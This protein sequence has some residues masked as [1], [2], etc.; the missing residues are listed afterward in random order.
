GECGA[1]A[2][3]FVAQ[4]FEDGAYE[5]DHAKVLLLK[6]R[7]FDAVT[8]ADLALLAAAKAL[9]TMEGVEPLSHN[10]VLREFDERVVSQGLLPAALWSAVREPL[11]SAPADTVTRS[12]A[13]L[14]VDAVHR[15]LD[16][17]RSHYEHLTGE[18]LATTTP[19]VPAE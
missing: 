9:L 12:T 1:A 11:H 2:V 4:H 16:A 18:S 17:C 7:P 8:R 10:D 14:H 3:N 13:Q 15:F 19:A 6:E 5:L